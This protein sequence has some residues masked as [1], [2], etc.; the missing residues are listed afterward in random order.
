MDCVPLYNNAGLI[1]KI[2][3]EIVRENAGLFLWTPLGAPSSDALI[4][5]RSAY[6]SSQV[7]LNS[8][9]IWG[10]RIN[11]DYRILSLRG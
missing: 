9:G 7:P 3:E 5:S 2:S 10:A 6:S 4:G 1:S 11:T 8:S